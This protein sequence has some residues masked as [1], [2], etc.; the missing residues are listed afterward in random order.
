MTYHNDLDGVIGLDGKSCSLRIGYSDGIRLTHF[1]APESSQSLLGSETPCVIGLSVE[2]QMLNAAKVE[3]ET[4]EVVKTRG[5]QLALLEFWQ[6][7]KGDTIRG[8]IALREK[9]GNPMELTVQLSVDWASEVPALMSIS[10]PFLEVL[11]QNSRFYRPGEAPGESGAQ[12]FSAWSFL[13]YPP[14]IIC[15]TSGN[16]AVGFELPGD[17]PFQAN[18]NHDLHNVLLGGNL[19]KVELQV[20][21]T[22]ELSEIFDFR[23]HGSTTGRAGVFTSWKQNIRKKYDLRRYELPGT[24]WCQKAYLHHFAFAYGREIFDY[25]RGVIDVD[26]LFSDGEQFGGYDAIIYWPQYPRLGLDQRTQWELYDEL[27]EGL[28]TL[29]RLADACHRRGARFFLPF[30]PWDV[31]SFESLDEQAEKIEHLVVE[32]GVDGFFLDTLQM[33]PVSFTKLTRER[34]PELMFCSEWT[35]DE[36][37]HIEQLTGSWDQIGPPA[38]TAN[39]FRFVFPE[40]PLNMISRWSVGSEKDRL[41]KRAA[42]NGTGMVVWQDIFG[43][44]LPYDSRQKVMIARLKSALSEYHDDIFGQESVPLIDTEAPGLVANRFASRPDQRQILSLH[45]STDTSITGPFLS[46]PGHAFTACSLLFGEGVEIRAVV[47]NSG[48]RIEGTIHAGDVIMICVEN[49]LR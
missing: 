8:R 1:S 22:D 17:Y 6:R 14:A 28:N 43:H 5:S 26:R 16:G 25:E 40:H 45:N 32:T 30:K 44:W 3:I 13:E 19:S 23:L 41:I 24:L 9:N 7:H 27:P 21:P 11:S 48:T 29:K 39:L 46:I 20:L 18:H 49:P 37:A 31:R 36:P 33:T 35:P 47:D 38:M 10:L 34:F 4:A 2:G 12:Q 42:F 15:E